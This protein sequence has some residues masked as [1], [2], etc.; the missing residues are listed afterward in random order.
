MKKVFIVLMIF[1]LS[2]SSIPIVDSE[3]SLDDLDQQQS[4]YVASSCLLGSMVYAQSFEPSLNTLAH[5]ELFMKKMGNL[6]GNTVLSIRDSLTGDDLTSVSKDSVE[7]DDELEWV[8]FDFP[9][10]QVKPGNKYYIILIPDPDSD[11][12]EGFNYLSWA[13]GLQDYYQKGAAYLKNNDSWNEG[14]TSYRSADYTFKS[15]GFDNDENKVEIIIS[16]GNFNQDIGFG[17]SIDVLNYDTGSVMVNYSITRDRYFVKDFPETYSNNF[18]APPEEYY[19]TLIGIGNNFIIYNV[20]ISA[21]IGEYRM[22]RQG[23]AIGELVI[24]K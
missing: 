11:G 23:I 10:I 3:A 13:F 2:V 9:D 18:T 17:V 8:L 15:Y 24:L 22:T 12:G 19:G 20:I 14:T 1:L 5:V 21:W 6:F 7:I 16:T 4:N